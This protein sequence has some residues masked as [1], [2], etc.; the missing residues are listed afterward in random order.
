[1]G[2]TGTCGQNDGVA[3][4]KPQSDT[5]GGL[6][7]VGR[8]T[9]VQCRHLEIVPLMHKFQTFGT[10]CLALRPK[11]TLLKTNSWTCTFPTMWCVSAAGPAARVF[12]WADDEQVHQNHQHSREKNQHDSPLSRGSIHTDGQASR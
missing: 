2:E 6:N 4:A 7:F 9:R 3:R 5:G 1:M 10:P 8:G 11:S 12:A